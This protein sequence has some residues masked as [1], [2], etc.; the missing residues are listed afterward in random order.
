M[1]KKIAD[2]VIPNSFRDLMMLLEQ[3]PIRHLPDGMTTEK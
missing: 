2:S 3:I 1:N